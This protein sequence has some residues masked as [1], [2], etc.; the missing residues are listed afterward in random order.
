MASG[1]RPDVEC[2]AQGV[3]QPREIRRHRR[4]QVEA[5]AGDRVG[6][7]EALGVQAP[8]GRARRQL[9]DARGAAAPAVERV[10]E[11]RPAGVG[12]VDPDLVRAP[13]RQAA[14]DQRAPPTEALDH[15]PVGDRGLARLILDE[16]FLRWVGWRPY[17]VRIVPSSVGGAGATT[18]RYSRT[19]PSAAG[20]RPAAPASLFRLNAAARA[21]V[22]RL[23]LGHHHHARG[24]LV[25]AM[26]DA[27]PDRA[28][29][30]GQLAPAV[31]EERVDQ[32]ARGVARR[33]VHH[34]ARRLVD[35]DQVGVLEQHR[36]RE[37]LGRHV[38]RRRRVEDHHDL[39]AGAQLVAR[40]GHRPRRRPGRRRRRP[41][42]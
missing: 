11:Q 19:T 33:R 31:V 29:D 30:A 26:D 3:E 9:G 27:R 4:A 6:Q 36:Q 41:G 23:V 25:E 39:V 16:N 13:G 18:A 37:V 10:A 5:L 28:A 35:R 20:P 24:V 8:G 42:A 17:S 15:A 34:Q 7:R 12:D 40:L 32:R 1:R 22:G 14:A 38:D 21:E 2:A